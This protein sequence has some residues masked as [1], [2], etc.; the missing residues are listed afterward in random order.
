MLQNTQPSIKTRKIVCFIRDFLHGEPVLATFAIL[1]FL[2]GILH[3]VNT[4]DDFG[5]S[6]PLQHDGFFSNPSCLD[7]ASA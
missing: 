5:E 2:S 4:F 7:L 1:S 6:S 3:R